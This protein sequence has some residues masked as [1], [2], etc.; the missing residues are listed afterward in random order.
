MNNEEVAE[1]FLDKWYVFDSY[2]P[3]QIEWK[4]KIWPTA[5][6]AYQAAHF[7]E[8]KPDLAEQVRLQRSPRLADEFANSHSA[9]DD[10]NWKN[11]RLKVM[12]EICLL[13]LKQHKLI[14][15]TLL[16]SGDLRLVESNPNDYFWGNGAD[17]SG[18]NHLGM[19][20]MKLRRELRNE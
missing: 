15:D 16:E 20:W 3:F 2:A 4:E 5:E 18:E 6:H 10:P 17:D 8:T 13:K 19:I 12:E 14:Q 11:M 7:F 9:D 1:F